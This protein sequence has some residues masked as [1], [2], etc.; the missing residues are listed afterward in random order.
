MSLNS[1]INRKSIALLLLALPGLPLGAQ[2]GDT[3]GEAPQ[4]PLAA[5]QRITPD[6][7][8]SATE[9]LRT[10]KLAPGFR[11]ELVAAEPMVHDP[12]AAAYDLEGNLW[13]VEFTRF[14]AGMVKDMPEMARGVTHVPSSRIVKL[15][16]THHDGHFDRRI[17]WL[18]GLE[19]LRGIAIVHDGV[20]VGDPPNLWLAKEAHGTGRCDEK[21]LLVNNFGVPGS[22]EDAGS[23]LWGR[24]NLL[25][26][27]SFVYDYHYHRGQIERLP[28]LMR[29]QFGVSQDDW[30]RLFFSRNSDQLRSDLFAPRYNV[31]NPDAVDF[32]WA[33]VKVAQDQLVWPSHPTPAVNRGYRLD[34]IG[35][36]NGG[37]RDDGTLMQFTA[38]CGSLVYRGRNFPGEFYG[39]D[40]VPEP[41]GNLVHRDILQE[42]NGRI[43]AVDAYP[44][45]EFLT[46][47]DTR[48]RPVGLVNP[49]DGSMLVLDMYRGL[50]EEYHITTSYLHQQTLARGLDQPMF[51]LGRIWKI[52]YVGGPLD[53][54]RPGLGA[55]TSPELAR[56]LGNPNGWWRDSAQQELVERGG[57]EAVPELTNLARRAPDPMTRVAALWTL[58]GLEATSLDLLAAC[59]GDSSPMVRQAAVRLHERFLTGGDRVPALKAVAPLID[60]PAPEVVIQLALTLGEDDDAEVF[61]VMDR[62]LSKDGSE[63]F[64]P[65]ALA[66]GLG[67]REAEF[68]RLL[69]GGT[70]AGTPPSERSAMYELL[71]S[72]IVHRGDPAQTARLVASAGD[73]GG[74]PEWARAAVVSGIGHFLRPEYR[75]YRRPGMALTSK[76]VA[77]LAGSTDAGVRMAARKIVASLEKSEAELRARTVARPLDEA[78]RRLYEAG[79]VT[80]Q[81]CASCHQ[82][83]GTGLPN[84]APSLVDSQ[85]VVANPELAVRIV[86]NG[87]EGTLGFPGAMPPIGG[88][89][90]DEQIAGV[91]TY[92]RNSWGL[93]AGAVT[94]AAVASVR[95]LVGS[96][97]AAWNDKLLQRTE[98]DLSHLDSAGHPAKGP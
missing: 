57:S 28:V 55:V 30:G 92:I 17:E 20:L 75:R 19:H 10:F 97:L 95:A 5:V 7:V 44:R 39:N 74:L 33:N 43:L 12:V 15:V 47:T 96:R 32:P 54:T 72:S 36:Q 90:T 78:E 42:S 76:E 62:L 68:M 31:R 85:W 48:F 41:A 58:D 34:A 40:F 80:F 4:V 2:M 53:Q 60:D 3:L 9:E 63:S 46:S 8:H 24:D 84:V 98:Y 65:A 26:D 73:D 67:G 23:L 69:A 6:P 18:D 64:V 38:A 35:E 52:T 49:P 22:D 13:V 89:L 66:T 79:H 93:H 29:G 21:I 82:E 86:L 61:P 51:G 25:H 70:E 14:N 94:P 1:R 77:P 87:K 50:L 88:A 59:L 83:R 37:L 91:L 16:S 27:I 71:A 11:I 81:I 56:V 45:G